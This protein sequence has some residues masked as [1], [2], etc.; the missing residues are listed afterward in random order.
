M[1]KGAFILAIGY[2][3]GFTHAAARNDEIGRVVLDIKKVWAEVGEPTNEA[4]HGHHGHVSYES[5]LKPQSEIETND[6]GES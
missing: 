4:D 2:I 5:E 1:I 3:A 6:E